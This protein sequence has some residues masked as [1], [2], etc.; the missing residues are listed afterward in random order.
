MDRRSD[1][2]Q[3]RLPARVPL[4]LASLLLVVLP[5][6][7]RVAPAAAYPTTTVEVRGHG[8]GHGRGMGQYGAIGYAKTFGWTSAQILDHFYGG[9]RA[10]TVAEDRPANPA[11]TVELTKERGLSAWV[12]AANGLTVPLP[13]G[14]TATATAWYA[15]RVATGAWDLYPGTSCADASARSSNAANKTATVSGSARFLP[16]TDTSPTTAA[17][18]DMAKTCRTARHYR[19]EL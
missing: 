18:A 12:T 8:W 7:G 5:V 1:P 15:V 10:G 11:F 9:T 3:G 13:T 16:R 14:G 2:R 6:V 4:A 17:T 19:G